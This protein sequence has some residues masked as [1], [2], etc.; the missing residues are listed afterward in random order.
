[1]HPRQAP[2][3]QA[4]A[5]DAGQYDDKA[6]IRPSAQEYRRLG[7]LPLPAIAAAQVGSPQP[8]RQV[9]QRACSQLARVVAPVQ[10]AMAIRTAQGLNAITLLAVNRQQQVEKSSASFRR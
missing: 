10:W 2:W 6:G 4:T 3:R 9:L 5:Q 7:H 1:L 8:E